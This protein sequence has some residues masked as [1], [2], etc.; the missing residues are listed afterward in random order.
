MRLAYGGGV[1]NMMYSF[2]RSVSCENLKKGIKD[3][4]LPILVFPVFVVTVVAATFLFPSGRSGAWQWWLSVAAALAVCFARTRPMRQR[5][6]TG[7]LF[8]V[9]LSVLWFAANVMVDRVG[10]D[11]MR[12]HHPAIRMMVEGWNPVWNGT[13]DGIRSF[14]GFRPDA[15]FH[16]MV[17]PKPVWYYSAAAYWFTKAPFALTS[18]LTPLLF[19]GLVYSVLAVFRNVRFVVRVSLLALTYGLIVSQE[20]AVDAT[21]AIGA[22]GLIVSMYDYLAHGRWNV[23]RLI[24]FSFWMASSKQIGLLHCCLFWALFVG[25]CAVARRDRALLRRVPCVGL[26]VFL[27]FS[28]ASFSPYVSAFLEYGH[29]LYPKYTCDE[30]RFP[31]YNMTW[32]FLVRNDAAASMGRFG[33][34]A[35][36]FTTSD[37]TRFCY[38]KML[39]MPQFVPETRTWSQCMP[40]HSPGAPTTTRFRAVFCAGMLFLLLFGGLGGRFVSACL[41]LGTILL[42]VEMIGYVRYTPW[43]FEFFALGALM[44]CDRPRR[45]PMEWIVLLG[46]AMLLMAKLPHFIINR[47]EKIECARGLRYALDTRPPSVLVCEMWDD[48]FIDNVW[49]LKRQVPE[50]KDAEVLPSP[51]VP[52]G[53][54]K[55][56]VGDSSGHD[57][58]FGGCFKVASGSSPV[59]YRDFHGGKEMSSRLLFVLRSYFVTLPA[60]IWRAISRLASFDRTGCRQMKGV[61]K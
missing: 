48:F 12:Y 36:A 50:L 11:E 15:P 59:R 16:I 17:M 18:T 2:F 38:G 45:K 24:M 57:V 31:S 3:L 54:R 1:G 39:D 9:V 10:W 40:D 30:R 41:F 58:F 49:L 8:L 60:N 23:L 37:L 44:A 4:E 42:P 35:N 25:V 34:W 26:S 33:A 43:I 55:K 46:S 20:Y 5:C 13:E 28:V 32:D 21:V 51:T 52:P 7:G 27:L 22:T 56:V 61:C 29:P 47:A 53:E 19:L 6:M 14:L